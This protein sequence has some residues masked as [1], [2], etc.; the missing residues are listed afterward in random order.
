[1]SNDA[2]AFE[3][4]VRIGKKL[5]ELFQEV[6]N[7]YML[8]NNSEIVRL[9]IKEKYDELQKEKRAVDLSLKEEKK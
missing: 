6:K 3:I 8:E 2:Q 7:N 9:L 1:M 5:G 4:R